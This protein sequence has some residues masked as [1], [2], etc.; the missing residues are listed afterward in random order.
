LKKALNQKRLNENYR[1][2][3]KD[4]REID[5]A[6]KKRNP[7]PYSIKHRIGYRV[8]KP[9]D[10]VER[11]RVNPGNHRSGYDDPHIKVKRYIEY[12]GYSNQEISYYKHGLKASSGVAV[13]K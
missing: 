1:Q 3:N 10:R 4:G 6:E 13:L 11:V 9:Y 12:L 5:S 2:N 8:Q 7:T